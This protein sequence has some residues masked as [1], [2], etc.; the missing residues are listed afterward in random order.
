M[1]GRDCRTAALLASLLLGL[2]QLDEACVSDSMVVVIHRRTIK[3]GD[4]I[5]KVDLDNCQHETLLIS[6]NDPA[7]NV[8]LDGSLYAARDLHVTSDPMTF[9]V[10]LQDSVTL[11]TWIIQV[12]LQFQQLQSV[13][14]RQVRKRRAVLLRR[15]K[16]RWRPRPFTITENDIGPFPKR[17]QL[18]KSEFEK[19][20]K[21]RYE[22]SGQGVELSPVGLLTI[23]PE[24]GEIQAMR[25]VDREEYPVLKLTGFARFSPEQPLDLTIKILDV[26]DNVPEFN[27]RVFIA[28][29]PECSAIGTSV[30][31]LTATDRDEP[32]TLNTMLRYR[33]VTQVPSSKFGV[34]FSVNEKTGEIKTNSNKLNREEHEKYTL[35]VEVRDMDGEPYGL[36]ST[37][38]VVIEVTD[39]NDHAPTFKESRYTINV[40]EAES[41]IMVLRLPIEDKDV[42]NTSA[43]RAVFKIIKGDEKENFNVTTDPETNDGLLYVVK[44][45]DAETVSLIQLEVAVEN[46]APLVGSSTG[47]QV[48]RVTV[49]VINVDEGPEFEPHIKQLWTEENVPLGRVLGSYTAKDPETK[50]SKGIR[51]RKLSDPAEWISIDSKTG[52]IQTIAILD[53]ESSY[54]KNN[55]YN[56]TVLAIEDVPSRTATGTVVINLIDVNDN[57]P[58]ISNKDLHIC[59]NGDQQFVNISAEDLDASPNAAPFTFLLADDPPEIKNKWKIFNQMGSFAYMK[60]VDDMIPGYFEVPIIVQDQQHHESKETLKI[61]ICECPNGQHCTGRLSSKKAVLGGLGILMMF[62]AALLLLCLLVAAFALHCGRDKSRKPPFVPSSQY[63]QSLIVSNEEGGGQQD[64]NLTALDITGNHGENVGQFGRFQTGHDDKIGTD[65]QGFAVGGTSGINSGSQV[66]IKEI[67]DGVCYDQ[68]G[69]M[70]VDSVDGTTATFGRR[71]SHGLMEILRSQ[72]D[73]VY[74]EEQEEIGVP[75]DYVHEYIHE[76]RNSVHGS[77]GSDVFDTRGLEYV[78]NLV[79][80]HGTMTSISLKK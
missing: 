22:I 64:M 76:G 79:P 56:V 16:R 45:L 58:I 33:I 68:H 24:T 54:V 57:R 78:P 50:S 8:E 61:I 66:V 65:I 67:I 3:A 2:A 28:Q 11:K 17:V 20:Y 30:L 60:P 63:Q 14:Q 71:K 19:D 31:N 75:Y 13:L 23:N 29:V 18:I 9:N 38:T 15:Q 49:N 25:S 39:M 7:I 40:K 1:C 34:L 53:R 36:H 46:E 51:Y 70:I 43:S 10:Q 55:K 72:V 48:T 4:L 26:N 21:I 42:E 74:E 69:M 32:R 5:S 6:T 35:T 44:P 37:G 27:E 12:Q 47:M 80:K 59:E 73:Q 77:V 41:D 52:Q 62:L